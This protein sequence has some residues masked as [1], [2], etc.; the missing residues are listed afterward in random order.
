MVAIREVVRCLP[1]RAARLHG[2]PVAAPAP[3]ARFPAFR[4]VNTASSAR[5]FPSLSLSTGFLIGYLFNSVF[6]FASEGDAVFHDQILCNN[7]HFMNKDIYFHRLLS[8]SPLHI[9]ENR[10]CVRWHAE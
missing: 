9:A 6:G 7:L 4:R 8:C 5:Q 10:R 2:L 3:Q 1:A